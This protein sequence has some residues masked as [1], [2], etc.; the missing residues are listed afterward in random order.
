[1][2]DLFKCDKCKAV[3]HPS[4]K[5]GRLVLQELT[6]GQPHM[7]LYNKK[8]EVCQTCFE[9]LRRMMNQTGAEITTDVHITVHDDKLI[10]R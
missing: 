8:A 1:M 7:S 10:E 6:N 9:G 5:K 3:L 4:V 2:A